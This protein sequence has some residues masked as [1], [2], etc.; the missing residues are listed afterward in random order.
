M[1]IFFLLFIAI[2][3]AASAQILVKKGASLLNINELSLPEILQVFLQIAK[4]IYILLGL[5]L[6][7]ISFLLWLFV[8]SKKQLN[9]AYPITASVSIVL[10]SIFSW[11][12]FKETLSLIQISGIALIILGVFLLTKV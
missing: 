10:V 4:N 2:F 8:V 1:N 11:I 7:G 9:V 6:I 12:L 5:F 3:F